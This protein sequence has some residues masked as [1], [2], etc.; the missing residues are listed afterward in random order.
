M[1]LN[2]KADNITNDWN[3]FSNHSTLIVLKNV[4]RQN[5]RQ[6]MQV[7]A[8]TKLLLVFDMVERLTE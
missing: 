6:Q 8:R 1:L 4:F 3:V 2:E 5:F 7:T